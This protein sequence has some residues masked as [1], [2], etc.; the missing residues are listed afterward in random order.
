MKG[1]SLNFRCIVPK[2]HTNDS[3]G[4]K[5]RQP[6]LLDTDRDVHCYRGYFLRR[7]RLWFQ[8]EIFIVLLGRPLF[9]VRVWGVW[10]VV[11]EAKTVRGGK[12]HHPLLGVGP[13]IFYP[14][15]APRLGDFTAH[16][17]RIQ[18]LFGYIGL[19]VIYHAAPVP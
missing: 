9:I 5:K 10:I 17:S 19:A 7:F 14:V 18:G 2:I 1:Q 8:H 12:L 16:L 11:A 4:K 6:I 13:D 3:N 15:S